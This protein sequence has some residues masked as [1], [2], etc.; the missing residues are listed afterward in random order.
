MEENTIKTNINWF[1]GHMAKAR[2]EISE[3]LKLV[4]LVIELKD[5]R[6]PYA[7]TNP[8]IHEIVGNKPRLILL[9][10]SSLADKTITQQWIK[11][12]KEQGILALDID[13][14]TGYH[15]KDI[16]TYAN[17]A[18]KDVFAKRKE[19][20]IA[21]RTIKAM[22]LGIP[23]VGKSTLI[24]ALA[25]RKATIV[26]DRPGVTKNQTWIKITNDLYLLDT[27][28]ILWPKFEDQ[29]VAIRL[30]MCG[31]IKDDILDIN[32]LV[33]ASIEY[34]VKL[35]PSALT[36]RYKVEIVEDLEQIQKQIGKN[37]GF[38]SKGGEVDLE[39]TN[40][41]FLNELRGMKIGAMSYERPEK[42]V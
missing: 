20:Q 32:A 36:T 37:R 8:M 1:P 39:R 10:K 26:G 41:M 5:A 7:S 29:G 23:N 6:I 4:D 28:G 42:S 31:S 14:I 24:N 11:H 27:P 25:K 19:K 40:R 13:S 21:S 2:R 22:I 3:K 16:Y 34:I 35:Y 30:A 12:Y 18:L 33:L 17:L 15:V 9:C 38:L